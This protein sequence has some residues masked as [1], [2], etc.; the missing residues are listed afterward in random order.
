MAFDMELRS[1]RIPSEVSS[2]SSGLECRLRYGFSGSQ[3]PDLVCT[4]RMDDH[5]RFSIPASDFGRLCRTLIGQPGR[6]WQ[7]TASRE[8]SLDL[9]L[10]QQLSLTEQNLFKASF[11]IYRHLELRLAD[12]NLEYWAEA[13]E[14]TILLDSTGRPGTQPHIYLVPRH[15]PADPEPLERLYSLGRLSRL[16]LSLG[17]PPLEI[18]YTPLAVPKVPPSRRLARGDSQSKCAAQLWA[19]I[20]AQVQERIREA[21]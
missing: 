4:C 7:E 12:E 8:L 9:C 10:P 17:G 16:T 21:S 13:L 18:H 15:L 5:P 6:M 2:R 11:L 20:I 1:A 14:E 3:H 19:T